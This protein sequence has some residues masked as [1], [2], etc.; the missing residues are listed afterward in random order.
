MLSSISA[1]NGI[2]ISLQP[3]T[4]NISIKPIQA[5]RILSVCLYQFFQSIALISYSGVVMG[6]ILYFKEMKDIR[7]DECWQIRSQT[8][9]LNA[10]IKECQQDTDCLLSIP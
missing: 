9:I 2:P 4:P 8:D 6:A 7:R 3:R 1:A 10:K 5:H